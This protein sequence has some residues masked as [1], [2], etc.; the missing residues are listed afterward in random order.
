MEG[1]DVVQ[2]WPRAAYVT[3]S[4]GRTPGADSAVATQGREGC[5]RVLKCN[6]RLL[7]SIRKQVS[8]K[9]TTTKRIPPREERAIGEDGGKAVAGGG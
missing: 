8:R 9:V 7:K 2:L 5:V 4:A 1:D 6:D 3:T